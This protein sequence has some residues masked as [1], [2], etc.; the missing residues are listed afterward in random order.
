MTGKFKRYIKSKL[1]IYHELFTYVDNF[2]GKLKL[3]IFESLTKKMPITPVNTRFVY[4]SYFLS[5]YNLC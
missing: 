2:W 5:T 4:W 3:L 1:C